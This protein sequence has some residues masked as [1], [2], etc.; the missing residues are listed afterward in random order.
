MTLESVVC[1]RWAPRA[2]YRSSYAPDT[3]NVLKDMVRRNYPRRV[4]FIC[5]TDD[6]SGIDSDVEI[7]ADAKD[8]ADVPS[9]HGGRNPSCYRRLR[10]FRPDIGDI[11]GRR[12]VSLD[13]DT[14][15]TG[16][17][18]PLWDRSE[19]IVFWG[20]TNP[21]KGSHYNGSMVLMTAGA[22]PHVWTTFDPAESPSK[23]LRAR[24]WGSDQGWI[25]CVL[26]PGE[27]KWS[28][29]DGVYSFRN[30]IER[31][32]GAL[33][34]NARLVSFHGRLDPWATE[35]QRLEWVKQHYRRETAVAA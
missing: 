8:F 7:I 21:Q 3:V 12:F 31:R 19:D 14:V 28:R 18:S 29:A 23:A 22:R 26:G 11:L 6:A 27:A 34:S 13:L 30:D 10:M 17:L 9:P 35:A 16:D 1:W 4:R 5:V 33:P 25:S 24:A 32:G 15:I 20:D 2:G